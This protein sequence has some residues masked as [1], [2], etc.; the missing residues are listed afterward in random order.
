MGSCA[1]RPN[2]GSIASSSGTCL[3]RAPR[4]RRPAHH[5]P[6]FRREAAGCTA[7]FVQMTG[8]NKPLVLSDLSESGSN[9]RPPKKMREQH[10]KHREKPPVLR[11]SPGYPQTERRWR[12]LTGQTLLKAR[13][14]LSL[15]S[16]AAAQVPARGLSR[17][18]QASCSLSVV[19]GAACSL[20]FSR[21]SCCDARS[22]LVSCRV[23]VSIGRCSAC[24]SP[25]G[26]D[27]AS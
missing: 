13:V 9:R 10:D 17:R 21:L 4:R 11:T 20:L 24:H 27:G 23:L 25:A 18:L 16:L 22:R 8:G 3:P 5:P 2:R 12:H 1:G 26:A 14:S 7:G 15:T 19:S 6:R